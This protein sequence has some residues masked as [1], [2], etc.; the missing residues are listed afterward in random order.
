MLFHEQ[1]V[2][3]D[4][5]QVKTMCSNNSVVQT[6]V[7]WFNGL[8]CIGDLERR[9]RS[10]DYGKYNKSL[11]SLRYLRLSSFLKQIFFVYEMHLFSG[12]HSTYFV[13]GL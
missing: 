6:V 2:T 11:A 8:F 9:Q 4:K 5:Y 10:L 12:D 1:F 13:A 3:N 7:K